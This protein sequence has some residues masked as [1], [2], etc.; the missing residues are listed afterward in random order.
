MLVDEKVLVSLTGSKARYRLGNIQRMQTA[1]LIQPTAGLFVADRA[2]TDDDSER[3]QLIGAI[4]ADCGR[5]T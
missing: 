4:D 5:D 2:L 1:G 3:I